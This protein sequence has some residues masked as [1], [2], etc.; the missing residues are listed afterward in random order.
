M[1]KKL[2]TPLIILFISNSNAQELYVLAGSNFT[3]FEFNSNGSPMSTP[4]ERGTGSTFEVGYTIPIISENLSYSVAVTLNEYNA[5]AGNAANSYE[6]NT[7]YLGAQ[8]SLHYHQKITSFFSLTAKA[9]LNLSTIIYG[10]QSTNG[11]IFDLV[12]QKEFSG[13]FF[14]ASGSLHTNYTIKNV[15]FLSLGYGYSHN[16]STSNNTQE[17]LSFKTSQLLLGFHFNLNP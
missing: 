14:G 6:W 2:L 8:S 1:I 9:G 13:L 12:K 16:I 4:L 15:G 3:S 11:E 10:K 5:L 17:K 7:K